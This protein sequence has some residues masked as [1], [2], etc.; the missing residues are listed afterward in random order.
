MKDTRCLVIVL[1]P[2]LS[3]ASSTHSSWVCHDKAFILNY[4]LQ[5]DTFVL[6]LALGAH[7][8]DEHGVHPVLYSLINFN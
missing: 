2:V 6:T 8:K 3:L 7:F 5:R 1:L 4:M